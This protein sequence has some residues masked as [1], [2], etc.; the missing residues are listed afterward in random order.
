MDLVKR[1]DFVLVLVLGTLDEPHLE[2]EEVNEV[3][4]RYV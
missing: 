1:R 3:N 4:L 2:E